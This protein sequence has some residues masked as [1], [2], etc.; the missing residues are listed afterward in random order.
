MKTIAWTYGM[1]MSFKE[2]YEQAKEKG[3]DVF[4]FEGNEFVLRYAYYLIE[5][6]E[7]RFNT[8]TTNK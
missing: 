2:A 5:Y 8:K 4:T 6:L 7:S 1:L 3:E